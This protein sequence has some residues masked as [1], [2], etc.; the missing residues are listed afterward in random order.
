M[1]K[2]SMYFE[3][4]F[5]QLFCHQIT[6]KD[7]KHLENYLIL[8]LI[9]LHQV[10]RSWVFLCLEKSARPEF[11]TSGIKVYSFKKHLLCVYISNF[12]I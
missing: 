11:S 12:S 8:L 3:I 2:I 5:F 10:L 9:Q 6:Q 4:Y 7:D 1:T